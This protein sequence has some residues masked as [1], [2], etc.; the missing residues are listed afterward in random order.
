MCLFALSAV[1]FIIQMRD[2]F[3]L[4]PLNKPWNVFHDW[5][6]FNFLLQ[7]TQR[8]SR[9]PPSPTG[10]YW[11]AA[12]PTMPLRFIIGHGVSVA[13]LRHTP[14]SRF[15]LSPSGFCLFLSNSP[16][17][18]ASLLRSLSGTPSGPWPCDASICCCAMQQLLAQQQRAWQP[19]CVTPLQGDLV[20]KKKKKKSPQT[21]E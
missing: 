2:L 21:P 19:F 1:K 13:P 10:G 15:S 8:E 3:F 16:P 12:V 14:S 4:N 9:P 6:Q 17:F 7:W 20:K 18:H 11:Q 5:R